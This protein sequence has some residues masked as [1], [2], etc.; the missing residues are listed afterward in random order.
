MYIPHLFIHSSVNGHFSCFH[1][2]AKVNNPAMNYMCYVQICPQGPTFNAFSF[3]EFFFFFFFL[4]P[5]PVAYGSSQARSWFQAATAMPDPSHICDLHHSSWRPW[6]LNPLEV[7]RDWTRI[8]MDVS[9]I[10]SHWAMMGTPFF[11]FFLQLPSFLGY[12]NISYACFWK[13]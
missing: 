5:A 7:A 9:Q 4:R 2:L 10:C 3:H 1:L 13:F 8:L 12:F 6:M 11:F